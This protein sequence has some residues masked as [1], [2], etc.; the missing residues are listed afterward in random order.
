[1]R[2]SSDIDILVKMEDLERAVALV[3]EKLSYEEKGPRLRHDAS[4]ISPSGVHFELHFSIL[5]GIAA[6]D[7][8][9]IS[10]VASLREKLGL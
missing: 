4:L 8:E 10:E 1:M 7:R 6:L 5:E 2:T 3:K 9:K